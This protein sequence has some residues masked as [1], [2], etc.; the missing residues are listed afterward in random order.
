M[1]HPVGQESFKAIAERKTREERKNAKKA[2]EVVSSD[3]DI[4]RLMRMAK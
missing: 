1:P 3:N 4:P 2:E